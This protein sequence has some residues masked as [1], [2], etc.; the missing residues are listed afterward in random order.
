MVSID[1][2]Q[3][4]IHFSTFA[5][6]QTGPYVMGYRFQSIDF[7]EGDFVHLIDHA[8]N[9]IKALLDHYR[10]LFNSWSCWLY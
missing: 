7:I 9:Q 2:L 10:I 8:G 6:C 5:Q 4:S 3:K 1:E